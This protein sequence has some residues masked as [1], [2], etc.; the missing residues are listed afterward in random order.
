MRLLLL[1]IILLVLVA[2]LQSHEIL[3]GYVPRSSGSARYVKEVITYKNNNMDVFEYVYNTVQ[4]VQAYRAYRASPESQ[5]SVNAHI[6]FTI[7]GTN[8]DGKPT[9]VFKSGDCSGSGGACI[10]GIDVTV[11]DNPLKF[12]GTQF[13]FI[14]GLMNKYWYSE[15]QPLLTE[16]KKNQTYGPLYNKII[17]W[18]KSGETFINSN[19]SAYAI[20]RVPKE[21]NT[22]VYVH[23]RIM[24]KP[25][26]DI[27]INIDTPETYYAGTY[28]SKDAYNKIV[29]IIQNTSK[30]HRSAKK[31]VIE[32]I[33]KHIT[34]I[35]QNGIL[36]FVQG[37]IR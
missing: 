34:P 30:T 11:T 36:T 5:K 9:L 20:C 16:L 23:I 15:T 28:S 19:A 31:Q 8:V 29:K 37:A 10:N 21:S 33:R 32:Y 18:I 12:E 24:R 13:A 35:E 26:G 3:G 6:M 17:N 1:L 14:K 7:T 4:T 2:L 22:L 25:N 27:Y